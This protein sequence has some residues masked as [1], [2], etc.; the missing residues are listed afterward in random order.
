MDIIGQIAFDTFKWLLVLGSVVSLAAG[1][2]LFFS[3]LRLKHLNDVVNN[4][5]SGRRTIKP[6]EIMRSMD[7]YVYRYNKVVGSLA[8]VGSLYSLYTFV[9]RFP[10]HFFTG[11]HSYATQADFFLSIVLESARYSVIISTAIG[12]PLWILLIFA[13][14]R[15]KKVSKTL[16]RWI[17]TRLMLRPLERMHYNTDSLIFK[18]HRAF[19]FLFVLGPAFILFTFLVII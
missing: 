5:L 3:P 13:P 9:L 6:L 12:I 17:S 7:I 1:I 2:V 8:F 19:G 10:I 14:E 4:Y 15:L 16:N 18:H 11:V